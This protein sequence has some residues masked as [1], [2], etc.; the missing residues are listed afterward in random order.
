LTTA[1]LLWKPK[2]V[3]AS[4]GKAFALGGAITAGYYWRE[5]LQALA[6]VAAFLYLITSQFP[7][8]RVS[9]KR[10]FY[11]TRLVLLTQVIIIGITPYLLG[12]IWS[13]YTNETAWKNIVL[14]QGLF[15]QAL[16]PIEDPSLGESK[17]LY[18]EAIRKS[19]SAGNFYSG[20]RYDLLDQVLNSLPSGTNDAQKLFFRTIL[21][22]PHR[23]FAAV[24]RTIMLFGGAGAG[25]LVSENRIFRG[26]ILSG[27]GAMIA[28]GPAEI[29]DP[30]VREF[31][32]TTTNSALRRLVINLCAPYDYL[33]IGANIA[34]L[35]GLFY[36]LAVRD[37]RLI[38]LCLLPIT[39]VLFYVFIL[40]SIDRYAFPA[41]PL[42]LANLIILP[43][44]Y[45]RRTRVTRKQI[46]LA[47]THVTDT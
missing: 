1:L 17:H 40:A 45:R 24:C 41:Y 31:Q 4:W 8:G 29:H 13:H 6:L 43:L 14:Q 7:T 25:A 46:Q 34:T 15:R 42:V 32:E 39:F 19:L 36:G 21:K 12:S 10:T 5:T 20:I 9:Q 44:M 3:R 18:K 22:H 35:F 23:Y 16:L 38:T 2:D 26:Q 11:A 37:F 30:I 33:V 27:T 47:D 28:D